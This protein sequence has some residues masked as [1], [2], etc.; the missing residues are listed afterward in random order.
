MK[1]GH[2]MLV[3][4]TVLFVPV[5]GMGCSDA[6]EHTHAPDAKH[7]SAAEAWTCSMHP[8]VHMQEAGR[9]PICGMD[10]VLANGGPASEE[11]LP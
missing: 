4:I 5:F 8:K 2:R 3:L 9:C 1:I 10:L 6:T 11:T 7:E